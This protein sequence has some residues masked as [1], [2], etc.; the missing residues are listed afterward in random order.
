VNENTIATIAFVISLVAIVA[1]LWSPT[2][3]WIKDR[4]GDA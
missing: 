2:T 4:T 1:L 3:K